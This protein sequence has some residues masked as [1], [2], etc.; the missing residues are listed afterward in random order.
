MPETGFA[1]RTRH[2]DTDGLPACWVG[3]GGVVCSVCRGKGGLGDRRGKL[4]RYNDA[5]CLISPHIAAHLY[6]L[7]ITRHIV[8][9]LPGA[10]GPPDGRAA[11][12]VV[13][14]GC[15]YVD[16]AG[17]LPPRPQSAVRSVDLVRT[18]CWNTAPA[19]M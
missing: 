16:V 13:L 1:G 10:D 14:S 6:L 17:V 15:Y 8:A 3:S 19:T 4:I 7:T 5:T 9:H 2:S 12:V 18:S 11:Q